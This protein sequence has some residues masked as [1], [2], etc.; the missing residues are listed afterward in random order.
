M[1]AETHDSVNSRHLLADHKSDTDQSALA[2]GGD[3]KH[4]PEEGLG[5]GVTDEAAFLLELGVHLL[6]LVADE[7]VLGR[8]TA[9]VSY[10]GLSWRAENTHPRRR[11]MMLV[12]LSQSSLL[13]HQRGLSGLTSIPKTRRTAGVH[14][15][16]RG[17]T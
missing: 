12:A 9:R 8:E 10:L 3:G 6:N 11:T 4:F 15:R 5:V 1:R 7:L 17:T 2:V 16:A 14:W 13:A